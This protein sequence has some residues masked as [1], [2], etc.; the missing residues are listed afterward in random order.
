M[1]TLSS[2]TVKYLRQRSRTLYRDLDTALKHSLLKRNIWRLMYP[3]QMKL[4]QP[5][6]DGWRG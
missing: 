2:V 1:A 4:W 5:K 3:L 6:P